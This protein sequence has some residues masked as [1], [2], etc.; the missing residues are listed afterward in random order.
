MTH[1]ATGR[2]AQLWY[3]PVK[4]MQGVSLPEAS[5]YWTGFPGDRRYAFT[6]A[7]DRS[8][9]P[10]LTGRELPALLR[11]RPQH[12]PLTGEL[13]IHTPS[14]QT[15]PIQ[16]PEL[17]DEL[18]TAAESPLHLLTLKRGA[19]DS[20]PLSLA[21][22]ATIEN[23]GQALGTAAPLDPR[24]FR[25]NLI[26]EG[27]PPFEE[28]RLLGRTIRVG[29]SEMPPRLHLSRRIKRCAMINLHPDTAERNPA[30]LR[31][32]VQ[33]RDEYVGVHLQ[34]LQPGLLRVGDAVVVE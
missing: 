1:L 4:S 25:F 33:T 7:N 22:T 28:E 19:Y 10:W 23:L 32:I 12:N 2:I 31:H 6:F 11:Y 27:W 29:S 21:S 14:G 20:M 30:I 18:S 24:R 26:I 3:Y 8:G 16:A 5:A 13:L 34:V 9:F 17:L 15:L